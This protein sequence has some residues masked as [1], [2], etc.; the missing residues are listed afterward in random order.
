MLEE[1]EHVS[2]EGSFFFPLLVNGHKA[3]SLFFFFLILPKGPIR[4][5][6]ITFIILFH[7]L[8]WDQSQ[9]CAQNYLEAFRCVA[10]CKI[11]DSKYIF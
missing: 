1:T 3:E 4:Q 2:L 5:I 10:T 11:F 7:F 6:T 9:L 8:L